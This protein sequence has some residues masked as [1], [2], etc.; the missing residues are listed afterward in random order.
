M[1][2]RPPVVRRTVAVPRALVDEAQSYSNDPTKTSFNDL[3]VLALQEYVENRRALAFAQA[4]TEMA[5][6]PQILEQSRR[7]DAE[8]QPVEADGLAG[9]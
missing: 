7:I 8:L 9:L 3:I 1:R 4:L 6:D 5:T 2:K